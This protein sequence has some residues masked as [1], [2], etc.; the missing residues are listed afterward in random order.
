MIGV[1]RCTVVSAQQSQ[2]N[3]TVILLPGWKGT[4]RGLRSLGQALFSRGNSVLLLDYPELAT[5]SDMPRGRKH[6][7]EADILQEACE[8]FLQP[9]ARAILMG[10]SGGATVAGLIA[11]RRPDWL[12]GIILISPV[13]WNG[14]RMRGQRIFRQLLLMYAYALRVT[15]RWIAENILLSPILGDVTNALLTTRGIQGFLQILRNSLPERRHRFDPREVGEHLIAVA[16]IDSAELARGVTV[17]VRLIVGSRDRASN[18]DSRSAFR[19]VVQDSLEWVIPGAGHLA[20]HEDAQAVQ[21]AAQ[22][23]VRSLP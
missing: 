9:E 1:Y 21:E 15:P 4:H 5:E 14:S 23:A 13:L 16:S 22:E 19:S 17:P 20:H 8:S 3:D 10:H 6:G 2:G 12:R 18:P 7:T 11:S